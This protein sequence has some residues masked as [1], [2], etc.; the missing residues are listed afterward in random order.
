VKQKV[1]NVLINL[2]NS[3]FGCLLFLIILAV[4]LSSVGLQWVVNSFVIFMAFLIIAPIIG[5]WIFKW[6][7][8]SNL[9]EDSCPVCSHTFT[10]FNNTECRCPNCGESLQVTG[11]KFER[12]TPEGIVDVDA[13]DVSVKKID[14]SN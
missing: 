6:W 2:N 11:G 13:I 5:F 1:Q 10:G 4:L 12:L 7:L 14:D 3:N 9:V 8:K